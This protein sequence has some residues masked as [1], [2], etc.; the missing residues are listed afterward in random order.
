[1]VSVGSRVNVPHLGEAALGTVRFVGEVHYAKGEWAGVELDE[2]GLGKNNGSV[3]GKSYFECADKCGVFARL[4]DLKVFCSE[5]NSEKSLHH[6][7]D[8]SNGS[9]DENES[10]ALAEELKVKLPSQVY[11]QG[12][13]SD[14]VK[15]L[16]NERF[17]AKDFM[18]AAA[19]YS[20]ALE[21]CGSEDS[22]VLLGNRAAC[23]LE[24]GFL[25]DAFEDA[26][27][28]AE[29]KPEWWK[30]HARMGKA[31]LALGE[32]AAKEDGGQLSEQCQEDLAAAAESFQTA[33]ELT[34]DMASRNELL[35]QK[36]RC[37]AL[38]TKRNKHTRA[39]NPVN[40]VSGKSQVPE[41]LAMLPEEMRQQALADPMLMSMLENEMG[42]MMNMG[43]GPPDYPAG[44]DFDMGDA[45]MPPPS[46]MG[47]LG[48]G[49]MDGPPK[50][51]QRFKKPV[52]EV[53]ALHEAVKSGDIEA[54][55]QALE[56]ERN[57]NDYD[58]NKLDTHSRSAL[59]WAC[60][61]GELEMVELLLQ[62][63]AAVNPQK[64]RGS[65]IQSTQ[66][67]DDDED[68]DAIPLF[69]AIKSG[70][71]AVVEK[72][73]A[74]GADLL[75]QEPIL[76][77]TVLHQAVKQGDVSMISLLM[78]SGWEGSEELCRAEDLRGISPLALAV[79]VKLPSEDE[80]ATLIDLMIDAGAPVDAGVAFAAFSAAQAGNDKVLKQLQARES[81]LPPLAA[82][83]P[84]LV[85]Q[86]SGES[87]FFLASKL[88]NSKESCGL[89]K[90]L[91]T[92]MGSAS[93]VKAELNRRNNAGYTCLGVACIGKGDPKILQTLL[94]LGA[95][96]NAAQGEATSALHIVGADSNEQAWELL[97]KRGGDQAKLDGKGNAPKLKP[98]LGDKCCMM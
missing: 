24:L 10:P 21:V 85:S 18:E 67:Q 64:K 38:L 25:E 14:Q 98:N 62:A 22:A 31:L 9:T 97:L 88:S 91:S 39:S 73:V 42:S 78:K 46:M 57:A 56:D 32:Q 96:V 87:I 36:K 15:R 63:G 82:R 6:T 41:W 33:A 5:G 40:A 16:G 1:M 35:R 72:L 37:S 45:S 29:L 12:V 86:S 61:R 70:N 55:R 69:F 58:I 28:A 7:G 95:D 44:S 75:T 81:D 26:E 27:K 76:G 54:L 11:A 79:R 94:D 53:L 80:R 19:L 77:H 3:K 74:S 90:A 50:E 92:A 2:A 52:L 89:L 49:G 23:R 43:Q 59:A 71:V 66:D 13:T 34:N 93:A 4:A 48:F 8:T 17:V 65:A 84:P 60:V 30:A 47:G 68:D 51:K 83:N 20:R